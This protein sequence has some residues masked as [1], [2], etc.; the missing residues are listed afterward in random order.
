MEICCMGAKVGQWLAMHVLRFIA[1]VDV[2]RPQLGCAKG[3]ELCS[4]RPQ[5]KS[6]DTSG[7]GTSKLRQQILELTVGY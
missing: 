2:Q 3:G 7:Q 6:D 4:I 5:H 1:H